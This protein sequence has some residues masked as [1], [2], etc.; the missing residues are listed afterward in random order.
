MDRSGPSTGDLAL[1]ARLDAL[2]HTS[3]VLAAML[4]WYGLG[5]SLVFVNK[6]MLTEGQFQF[7][8]MTV[9]ATNFLLWAATAALAWLQVVKPTSITW[10]MFL[11]QALPAGVC[12]G[13]D[14]GTANWSLM[15]LNVTFFTMIRGT[16]PTFV[17]IF[18]LCS[19]LEEVHG[20]KIASILMVC[21]GICLASFGEVEF[22]V[23]GIVM[24]VLSCTIAGSRWVLVQR[25]MNR[26][27]AQSGI[28]DQGTR[29]TTPLGTILLV[30]P[31]TVLSCVPFAVLFEL[32]PFLASPWASQTHMR[33]KAFYY[34]STVAVI[35]F[36]LQLSKYHLVKLTSSLSMSLMGIFKQLITILGAVIIFGDLLNWT[37]AIGFLTCT[38]GL[39][40]Y[41]A[42][43]LRRWV[44]D[45]QPST[46][47]HKDDGSFPTL[48]KGRCLSGYGDSNNE[49]DSLMDNVSHDSSVYEA[50]SPTTTSG[51]DL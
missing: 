29:V 14:I 30:T 6:H 9:I 47:S 38:A 7:P 25:M 19:G 46:A 10:E 34:L 27:S 3:R 13:L 5:M 37:K 51:K 33:I 1:H 43:K 45:V 16:I 4:S 40:I 24:C 2:T 21:F 48:A 31:V 42:M 36:L 39:L 49:F 44:W 20:L 22:N 50:T 18:G 35:A 8:F 15:Y 12:T 23:H 26:R 32:R 28:D 41:N 11:R 17:L